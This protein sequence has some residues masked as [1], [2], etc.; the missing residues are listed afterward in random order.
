M[1]DIYTSDTVL[2][3][4]GKFCCDFSN[5]TVCYS[6]TRVI[7]RFQHD[8]CRSG[9]IPKAQLDDQITIPILT[10]LTLALVHMTQ[11]NH[12]VSHLSSPILK[13]FPLNTDLYPF[14][15]PDG[16]PVKHFP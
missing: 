6:H 16:P 10:R 15:P 9:T 5:P 7:D 2:T 14:Q 11:N 8:N 13:N 12:S 3:I 4:F 1:V